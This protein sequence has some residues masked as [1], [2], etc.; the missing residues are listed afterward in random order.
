MVSL[1]NG[2]PER[3]MELLSYFVRD[4]MVFMVD[5]IFT[6]PQKL[7]NQIIFFKPTDSNR[8]CSLFTD[9]L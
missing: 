4:K 6:F 9:S 2:S 1:V 5:T 7:T 3:L 8:V